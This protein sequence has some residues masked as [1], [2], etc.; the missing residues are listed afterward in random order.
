MGQGA[1]YFVVVTTVAGLYR[2]RMGDIVKCV[3]YYNQSPTIEFLYRRGSLLYI[4]GAKVS[5]NEIFAAI[6]RH[7][8]KRM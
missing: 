2:Y 3:G 7:L 1:R 5:E 6:T 8:R 4:S